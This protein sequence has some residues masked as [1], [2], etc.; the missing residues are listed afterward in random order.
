MPRLSVWFIRAAFIHLVIGVTLGMLM[1]W[2]KGV[3]LH[4]QIWRLLPAHMDFLLLGW[5]L[6]LAMGVAFWILPRFMTSRGN[7]KPAWL[8]FFLVNI[9][10]W[11]VAV[12]GVLGMPTWVLTGRIAEAA[13]AVA[14][15]VHA[16]P[17]VK[18]PLGM[19]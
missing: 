1:L 16:W 9:G 14:F 2:N 15:A 12:G 11:M 4:P 13:S 3:P 17:R 5:T 19:E 18:P 7:V 10:V 8:A 6:Q